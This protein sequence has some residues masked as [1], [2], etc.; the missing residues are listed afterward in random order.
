[1]ARRSDNSHCSVGVSFGMRWLLALVASV[2]FAALG[3]M[4]SAV[5][6]DRQVREVAVPPDGAGPKLVVRAYVDALDARDCQTAATL[7][8]P[9]LRDETLSSCED[10]WDHENVTIHGANRENPRSSG[11]EPN[12]QV[13]HV[14]VKFGDD[15]W[16]YLLVRD[17]RRELWRI[18]D[19]GV[20]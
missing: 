13:A 10:G 7:V 14:M 20:G 12:Q 2:G 16:G 3:W 5:L 4:A 17:S 6:E 1:V 18:L 19:E 9:D 11:H 15:W 8:T